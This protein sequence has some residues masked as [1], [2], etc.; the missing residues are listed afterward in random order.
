[1]ETAATPVASY[2]EIPLTSLRESTWNPRKH[3]DEVK[4]EEL[5]ASVREKG[6]IEPLVV[7]PL[8]DRRHADQF[9]IVAG[10]RRFRAATR[11][12][13]AHVPVVIRDLSDVAA[14]ELAV[15]ENG[16]RDDV[17]P[18][19]EA[20]GY[21]AL[22]SADRA[23][24]A[25]VVA[26]KVGKSESYVYRRLKLLGLI[27]VL[28]R[29]FEADAL[30]AAHAERLARLTADQQQRAY[31]DVVLWSPMFRFTDEEDDKPEA[32]RIPNREALQ[33]LAE[34]DA[35]IRK[36]SAV[37]PDSED[38]RQYFPELEEQIQEAIESESPEIA[39]GSQPATLLQ[40]SEHHFVRQELGLAKGAPAPLPA[41]KWHEI[42]STRDRCK[43]VVAGVVVHGGPLRA[44][45][46]CATKGCPKH[47]PVKKKPAGADRSDSMRPPARDY[48]AEE[49]AREQ[50]REAWSAL[51]KVAAP[52][53]AAHVAK[54]K[55][56]AALVRHAIDR[57]RID[58]VK[59]L[60]G[61]A[62]TDKTAAQVLCL[63]VIATHD[64]PAFLAAVKPFKFNL[65]H[66]E[67]QLKAEAAKPKNAVDRVV[68]RALNSFVG[69]E[70]R[71]RA[72]VAKGLSSSDLNDV[73]RK[74]LGE[75][76][77]LDADYNY[78][79]RGGKLVISKP[80]KKTLTVA[81]IRPIVLRLFALVNR[82]KKK[83]A[84]A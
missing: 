41:N 13:L 26:A 80:V 18:L 27:P 51:V 77:C 78:E 84:A 23:Y 52:A 35:F 28:K 79:T 58:R 46:V 4:L 54:V 6:V 21:D 60:Y 73:I 37:D 40:L 12:G 74:E 39:D 30:T 42:T 1:M 29:A 34:L 19:D 8:L 17:H 76:G 65:G 64:R 66:V 5:T 48:A 2:R 49:R 75:G 63:S 59:E 72:A 57:Y 82:A 14:L 53:F 22:M 70:G 47:F 50:V 43:T 24:N 62:L 68:L 7:R 81:E 20:A 11:A 67:Q 61:V 69:G 25:A 45:T 15:I 31:D 10:A 3:F 33:P 55:F 71:V 36:V 38:A 16:Q 83:G 56:N 9:E 32:D 44:V